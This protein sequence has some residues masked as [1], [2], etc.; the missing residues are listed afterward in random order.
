MIQTLAGANTFLLKRA[1]DALTAVFIAEHGDLALE[2][3]DGQEVELAKLREAITSLPF[4]ANKKMVVLRAPGANKEFVEKIAQLLSDVPETTDVIIVEP[5]VDKR[6][7]YYK[8]LKSNTAFQEF[9]ELDQYTLAT[10]LVATAQ[11][12]GGVMSSKDANYLVE[13]VGA[14]QQ[15]LGNELEKL[16]L[17]APVITRPTIDDMT[18]A[19]PQST[20]FQM[21]EAVFAGNGQR[22]IELYGEQRALK[23]EPVQ[24]IAMIAWQLRILAIIKTAGQRSADAIAQEAKISPYVIRKSQGVAHKL[25]MVKLKALIADLLLIDRR[26]KREAIDADEVLQSY[27]LK[28][29]L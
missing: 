9:N 4:L 26:L 2:R 16:L 27:L 12:Q 7:S 8:F 5:K 28:L 14:N 11:E 24:I 22:A 25:T 29:T 23:I 1:L 17:Y 19:A 3:I 20:I 18:E 15:A 21:L 10:W 13:R 6:S